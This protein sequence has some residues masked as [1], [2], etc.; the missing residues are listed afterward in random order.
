MYVIF[1]T[2]IYLGKILAK[3]AVEEISKYP[4][5]RKK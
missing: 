3:M 2:S 1:N 4:K 5:N